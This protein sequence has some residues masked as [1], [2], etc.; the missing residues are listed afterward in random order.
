[1]IETYKAGKGVSIMVWACFS[2]VVGRSKLIIIERDPDSPKQGYSSN[3]YI[4]MLDE[5]LPTQWELGLT[6][7]QDNAPIHTSKKTR[8][9]FTDQS[10]PL[11]DH[12]PFSPDLNPIENLWRKLKELVYE[13][14]PDIDFVMDGVDNIKEKLGEALQEAWLLIP[15]SYF[16]AVIESMSKRVE[17]V[18][19]ANGWHT[20]Y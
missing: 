1:M 10:I 2:S 14:N 12:P 6:F 18:I 3:S 16:N 5:V 20:K 17:A 4:K 8:K 7:M 19:A 11:V 9:W 15:Q 13:V